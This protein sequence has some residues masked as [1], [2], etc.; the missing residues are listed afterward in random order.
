MLNVYCNVIVWILSLNLDII[1]TQQSSN[2]DFDKWTLRFTRKLVMCGNYLNAVPSSW[3]KIFK[4]GFRSVRQV[5]ILQRLSEYVKR[6]RMNSVRNIPSLP[7]LD[8]CQCFRNQNTHSNVKR[9]PQTFM[10]FFL[11]KNKHYKTYG[12]TK[13]HGKIEILC[14]KGVNFFNCSKLLFVHSYCP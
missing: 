11:S 6:V 10:F 4:F 7:S 12:N 13:N 9:A 5:T 3:D 1:P 8:Y 14:Q 2:T